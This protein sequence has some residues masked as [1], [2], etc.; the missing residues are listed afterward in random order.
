MFRRYIVCHRRRASG[1]GS[2]LIEYSL[3]QWDV[4]VPLWIM[5]CFLLNSHGRR[6]LSSSTELLL[7][8]G[9]CHHCQSA[10]IVFKPRAPRLSQAA[11]KT[12]KSF[13]LVESSWQYWWCFAAAKFF[14]VWVVLF[15][16]NSSELGVFFLSCK[17][18]C[19]VLIWINSVHSKKT[20]MTRQTEL[21]AGDL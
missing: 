12:S 10:F 17:D 11:S 16:S 14:L 2:S 21:L 4:L 15:D 13:P 8:Q 7:I 19:V 1:G 6:F 3:S 5:L 20:T 9:L 18:S